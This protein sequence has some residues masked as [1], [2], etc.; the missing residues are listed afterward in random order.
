M[1]TYLVL[2]EN[3]L[4]DDDEPNAVSVNADSPE[5]ALEAFNNNWWSLS[6][7]GKITI[8]LVTGQELCTQ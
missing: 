8:I 5:E 6:S 7:Y 4:T 3:P 2:T 1:S